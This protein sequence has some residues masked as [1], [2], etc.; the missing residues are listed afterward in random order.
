M[1]QRGLS[2]KVCQNQRT[3]GRVMLKQTHKQ[4]AAAWYILI[5]PAAAASCKRDDGCGVGC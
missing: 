2:W 4:R 5:R 3:R 1:V